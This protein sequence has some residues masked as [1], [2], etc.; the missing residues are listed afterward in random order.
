MKNKRCPLR[1]G[2]FELLESRALL[3]HAGLPQGMFHESFE[4]RQFT[5]FQRA[6]TME[7]RNFGSVSARSVGA[8][9]DDF[10]G[11]DHSPL[12]FG[13]DFN[14]PARTFE[15]PASTSSSYAGSS[16]S[17]VSIYTP[18]PTV[19]VVITLTT[20][21]TQLSEPLHSIVK[22]PPARQSQSTSFTNPPASNL[23]AS[24]APSRSSSTTSS[25]LDSLSV[26]SS[27]SLKRSATESTSD[28]SDDANATTEARSD[29][30]SDDQDG[31]PRAAL[32]DA[33]Q[34]PQPA[35]TDADDSDLIELNPEDLLKRAKRRAARSEAAPRID[36]KLRESN[37]L[38]DNLT[39]RAPEQLA[40]IWLAPAEVERV[41]A[42]VDDDLIELLAVDQMEV[43]KP[44]AVRSQPF[45]AATGSI[46]LEANLG[47]YQAV[48]T[49]E[50]EI[51]PAAIPAALSAEVAT[52]LPARAAQ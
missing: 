4:Q 11:Y 35:T 6:P 52:A 17:F 13:G 1:L 45:A 36:T 49:S 47:F 50:A 32:A 16:A 34:K 22:D 26:L 42:P 31:S 3:A 24:P 25:P 10:D 9:A 19:I 28:E 38:R 5:D 41:L 51:T 43:A 46:Q 37:A 14:S 21:A 27:L 8:D 15:S 40:E 2:S 23:Q 29:P 20:P 48:D 7:S 44:T 33:T 30:T 18:P 39:L 12:D